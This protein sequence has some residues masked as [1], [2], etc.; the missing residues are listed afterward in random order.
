MPSYRFLF[1]KHAVERGPSPEALVLPGKL[2]PPPGYEVVPKPAAKALA[3]YLVSLHAD[4]PLFVAPM[5]VASAAA[6]TPTN[7]PAASDSAA[8][9]APPATAPAK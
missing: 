7:S 3:A 9:N 6:A 4:A 5:T 2:A 8:T 1:A